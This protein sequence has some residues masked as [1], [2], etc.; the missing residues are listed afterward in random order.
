MAP[1][2]EMTTSTGLPSGR[3]MIAWLNRGISSANFTDTCSVPTRVT[4]SPGWK[5]AVA[6]GE[7]SMVPPTSAP[8]LTGDDFSRGCT[9]SPIQLR[10]T[11]PSL[12]IA[13]ATSFARSAGIAPARP[14]L[15]SLTPTISPFR[16]I[17]GPP[18]LPPKIAAS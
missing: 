11:R 14:R 17:S 9:S 1:L 3:R 16:L 10:F 8:E 4:M 12:M 7:P 2:R 15:I 18:E 6:A 13:N 5:P